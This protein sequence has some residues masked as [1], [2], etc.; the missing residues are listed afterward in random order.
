[1]GF[2]TSCQARAQAHFLFGID[3][4]HIA[5]TSPVYGPSDTVSLAC[6]AG[7]LSVD[8]IHQQLFSNQPHCLTE[9]LIT[10]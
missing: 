10:H 3:G 2:L 9:L 6:I 1:M 5:R 7:A 4:A 8:Y